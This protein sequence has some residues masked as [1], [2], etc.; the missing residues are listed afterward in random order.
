MSYRTERVHQSIV[1]TP[2]HPHYLLGYLSSLFRFAQAW[3]DA[4][5]RACLTLISFAT[6]LVLTSLLTCS[7]LI[8]QQCKSSANGVCS[9]V[10]AVCRPVTSGT[11][12]SGHCDTV[13]V[14][15]PGKPEGFECKCVGQSAPPPGPKNFDLYSAATD[16]NGLLYNPSWMWQYWQQQLGNPLG[17]IP[18]TSICH[19]FSKQG[20]PDPDLFLVLPAWGAVPLMS[21]DTSDCSNFATVDLPFDS[22]NQPT[23][24]LPEDSDK[25][26]C[27]T[28]EITGALGGGPQTFAGHVHWFPVTMEG[29]VG[30]G[31][32]SSEEAD[33][34]DTFTFTNDA[35]SVNLYVNGKNEIHSEFSSYETIDSYTHGEWALFHNAVDKNNPATAKEIFDGHT[36]SGGHSIVTG[37]FGL[38]SEH[39]LKSELHPVFAIATK[40]DDPRLN[41]PNDEA[42]LMFVRNQGNEGYC[43]SEILNAGFED[44][45][46]RLPWRGPEFKFVDVDRVNTKFWALGGASGPTVSVVRG[47]NL[48]PLNVLVK[49]HLGPAVPTTNASDVSLPAVYGTLH[50][51]WTTS[52]VATT[53]AGPVKSDPVKTLPGGSVLQASTTGSGGQDQ[54]DSEVG[55]VEQMLGAAAAHLTPAQRLVIKKASATPVVESRLLPKVGPVLEIQ[56]TSGIE[57]K[58]LAVQQP[59][60]RSPATRKMA[61]ESAQLRALCAATKN[62]PEGLPPGLCKAIDVKQVPHVPNVGDAPVH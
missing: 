3:K 14:G 5:I 62:V 54:S 44:Y 12:S 23:T 49:F 9:S 27:E 20:G 61:R 45:T 33:G 36:L 57:T 58:T 6:A 31:N 39:G 50:L 10:D 55:E 43:S 40:R 24:D 56:E 22:S 46:F 29:S 34:D 38:D 21:P 51:I 4:E 42:W 26:V 11:G 15:M 35:Q 37:L 7:L 32:E 60:S 41:S 47:R 17:T 48:E 16:K 1:V 18:N 28:Y 53:G 52:Q 2:C 8:A 13:P 19:D 59:I 30:W 25:L